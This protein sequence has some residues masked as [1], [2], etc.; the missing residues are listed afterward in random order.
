MYIY[1]IYIN[2]ER[3]GEE[4]REREERKREET[5]RGDKEEV[6]NYRIF[7]FFLQVTHNS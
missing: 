1:Y 4:K 5:K 6:R 3:G 2:R 7:Q